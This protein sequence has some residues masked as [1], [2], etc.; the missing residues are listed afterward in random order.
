LNVLWESGGRQN[1]GTNERQHR[2]A[3]QFLHSNSPEFGS[4]SWGILLFWL[5]DRGPLLS[6]KK[7]PDQNSAEPVKQ[8]WL[9]SVSKVTSNAKHFLFLFQIPEFLHFPEFNTGSEPAK[10]G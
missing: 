7:K 10:T 9:G 8:L 4:G 1:A 6:R 5:A 3:Q 2:T